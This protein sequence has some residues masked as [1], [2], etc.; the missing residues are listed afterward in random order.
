MLTNLSHCF[1]HNG[2]IRVLSYGILLG[3]V[4]VRPA[5]LADESIAVR[6]FDGQDI[7]YWSEGK[8]VKPFIPQARP[9]TEK[10]SSLLPS[11]SL[12]RQRDALPFDWK[13]YEDPQNPEFWDDGGD[14]VAPR[15]LREAVAN[16][17][18]ENLEKYAEWQARRV[19]ILAEFN[20]KLLLQNAAQK[21][22]R[23]SEK[24]TR[25]EQS[26]IPLNL[27]EVQL[28][29]FYQSSCP[30][31][32]AAKAQVEELRRKGVHVTFIQLDS[33]ESPPLHQP[34]VK[35]SSSLSKQFAVSAT[36]TWVFRRRESSVRL[37]GAQSEEE[38]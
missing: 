2:I 24:K 18:Q 38:L 5:A 27:R 30:H 31:C 11:G 15:P 35:Y 6:F 14:Y 8:R 7:D 21:D 22:S 19:A 1:R 33:E 12:I 23:I 29:Y 13:K 16:P 10:Q 32:Q 25:S 20:R 4:L 34:S 36:P 26:R 3:F 37:Q 17:S 9:V 28:L